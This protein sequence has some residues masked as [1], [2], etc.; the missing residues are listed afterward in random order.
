MAI[1]VL[2][3]LRMG[4]YQIVETR[5]PD[6][7][8]VH[9]TVSLVRSL[10][11]RAAGFANA[12][13]RKLA[14][15]QE[16]DELPQPGAE[17]ADPLEVLSVRGSHP[18]W[19]LRELA[20]RLDTEELAAWVEANNRRPRVSL[21]ANRMRT[22]RDELAGMLEA[23]GFGVERPPMFPDGLHVDAAGDVRQWPG[24]SDGLYTV[25]DLGAQLIARLADPK[26][27]QVVLDACAAPG[28]KTTHLPSS[29]ATKAESWLST[30]TRQ[31]PG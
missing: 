21:R 19:I 10:M 14:S 1:P 13:L 20:R 4:T 2:T 9:E 17:L 15:L 23:A 8:A 18:L 25:Q 16:A 30:C 31:R 26:A 24:F 22:T 29:S 11:P 27:G 5:V 12:V 3:A 6:H 28:G 7:A